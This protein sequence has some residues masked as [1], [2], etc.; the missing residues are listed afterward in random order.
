MMKRISRAMK[1]E[2]IRLYKIIVEQKDPFEVDI[3]MTYY[4]N[5][6]RIDNEYKRIQENN[7]GFTKKPLNL[8]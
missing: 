7:F 5:N 8:R 6:Y 2:V 4:S 1:K 3:G